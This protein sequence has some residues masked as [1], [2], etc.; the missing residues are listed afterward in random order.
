MYGKHARNLFQAEVVTSS[1]VKDELVFTVSL[2]GG[3]GLTS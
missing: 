3:D 1:K 2:R